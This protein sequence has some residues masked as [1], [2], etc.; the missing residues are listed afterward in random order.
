VDVPELSS[1]S[2]RENELE[3]DDTDGETVDRGAA[4]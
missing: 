2:E 1:V 3:A 4:C